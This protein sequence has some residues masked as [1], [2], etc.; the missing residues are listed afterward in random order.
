MQDFI[1]DI[2]DGIRDGRYYINSYNVSARYGDIGTTT[3]F[4]T[5]EGI[6]YDLEVSG[7][8]RFANWG[9][10]FGIADAEYMS[11]YG[12]YN[13]P[14]FVNGWAQN[15]DPD[16]LPCGGRFENKILAK[17]GETIS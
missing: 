5:S 11:R 3:E 1:L 6:T 7:T 14:G 15:P 17:I 2:N 13:I 16:N 10:D 4:Y 9:T 12:A 8:F